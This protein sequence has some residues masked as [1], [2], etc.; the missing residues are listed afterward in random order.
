MVLEMDWASLALWL[1]AIE[2]FPRQYTIRA[3]IQAAVVADYIIIAIIII[4]A[5]SDNMAW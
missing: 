1:Q 3:S 2:R 5:Y 4:A